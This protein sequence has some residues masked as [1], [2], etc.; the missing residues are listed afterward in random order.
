VYFRSI[1]FAAPDGLL[2]EIA[3]DGPGFTIDEAPGTLGASL[4][5]PSWL[6]PE[7]EGIASVL[8]PLG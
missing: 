8:T 1:Y 7:R 2:L 6:E 3:T 4:K 5:L